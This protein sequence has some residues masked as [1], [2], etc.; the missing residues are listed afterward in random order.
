[1]L[2]G[3]AWR[4][5]SPFYPT[6]RRKAHPGMTT[7]AG[8][9]GRRSV[10]SLSDSQR[11][12]VLTYCKIAAVSGAL[13]YL[14]DLAELLP[15][16]VTEDELERS[17]SS[18]EFLAPRVIVE[19]GRVLL[20]QTGSGEEMARE[21]SKE[22]DRRR[23][24]A[25][26]NVEAGR[27]FARLLSKDAVFTAV[28]GTNSYLSAAEHD[29][30]DFYCITKTDGMWVFM[31][32]SLVLSRVFSLT[33]RSEPAFDF[34]FV[35]DE[36]QANEELRSPKGALYARDALTAMVISGGSAYH[37]VLE[38]A[39]WIK[40]YFPTVYARKLREVGGGARAPPTPKKGSRVANM[41]LFYTLGSYV[42]L[43]A[44]VLNRKLAKQGKKDAIFQTK[45]GP[46]QLEYVS[47]RYM[48]LDKMYQALEKR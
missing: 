34:S 6:F 17:I 38:N 8:E 10:V 22:A 26:R 31:L 11:E 40:S 2:R 12:A 42:R 30:I 4:S 46:G 23:S 20:R 7:L 35:L 28:A 45:I 3:Y 9:G 21:A 16:D 47:R 32:K 18:D 33:R 14:N 48:E 13:L 15:I 1:M 25:I 43:R 27:T 41:W 37:A 36:R 24:R 39:S 29:D 5:S 19:A 44:W